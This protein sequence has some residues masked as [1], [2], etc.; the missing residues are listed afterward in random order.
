M[1]EP[2]GNRH[3]SPEPPISA[4]A[5][6]WA[7]FFIYKSS[8]HYLLLGGRDTGNS[9]TWQCWAG[10]ERRCCLVVKIGIQPTTN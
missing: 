10:L 3:T 4:T 7:Q 9:P 2:L 8:P 5:S 1:E 6:G